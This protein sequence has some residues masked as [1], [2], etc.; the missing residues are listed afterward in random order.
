[1][2]NSIARD[3]WRDRIAD[4][5]REEILAGQLKA[6]DRVREDT[7][8][9]RFGVSRV[10]VREALRR[11]ESEGFI[12]LTPYRGAT[13]SETSRR[14]SLEFMQV[15][16]GLEVLAAQLAARARGGSQAAELKAIVERGREAS[17]A[18]RLDEL[19]PLIMEFHEIVAA[20]AGNRRL[21]AMLDQVLRRISWGFELDLEGRLDSS[22]ADHA[23]IAQAIL[24]GSVVQAGYLMD[25]HIAKDE[26]LYQSIYPE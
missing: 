22:W 17:Q 9:E 2:S 20:A 4:A 19:P 1:V 12:T 6:G 25:E 21:V 13:V 15:R 5:V 24:S 14:D 26:Q 23:A 3:P 11:L 10:P 18:H 7:V 16:R 8:A